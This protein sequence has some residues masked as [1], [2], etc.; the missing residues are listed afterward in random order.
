MAYFSFNRL[1]KSWDS[2]FSK[3][4]FFKFILIFFVL[5]ESSGNLCAEE[6]TLQSPD[7]FLK[8]KISSKT[9]ID[10]SS[11]LFYSVSFNRKEAIQESSLGI[12]REDAA[13]I[14]D[15]K[16]V[17][18]SG[19]K[20]IDEK[21]ALKTGKR[22]EAH[23]YAKEQ[24]LTFK[25]QKGDL[26][27]LIV[28]AYNEGVAFRY[29]FPEKDPKVYKVMGEMTEFSIPKNGKAWIHQYDWNSRLKPSY[30]QY[31]EKEIPIGSASP[32]E[33]GWAYPMLFNTNGLWMM[34]TEAV[35]DGS[36]CG[37]HIRVTPKGTYQVHLAEP[38][39]AAIP[40]APEPVHSLPWAS[41]WR[42]I[43]VGSEL[44][45]IVESNMVQNLNEACRIKNT[46]WIQPG[47]ASWSWWS[48]GG[49]PR[50]FK[51][52]IEYVDF[53]A[54]MG[55]EYMLIDAGWPEMKGGTVEDVIKYANRKKVGIW[56]WYHSGSG[57]KKDTVTV[58]N[59]MSIPVARRAE[60]ARLHTLGVKGV[61][62]DF[63]DTDKQQI[64]KL[65]E[66]IL[67]DAADNQIM[68]NF[69]G[70]SLPR[71]LERTYPNLMTTEA[72]RGAEGFGRQERCD[73]APNFHTILPFTRNVVGSMDYTPVTFSNKI[74]QGVEAFQK[75]SYAHQLALSVIFES[76][77]QDF[78][79]RYTSYQALPDAPK[80]FLKKVPA[81]WD[82]TRLV[83]G[84]P[85][86]FVVMARRK[87]NIWYVAG[88][89]GK[90]EKR[91][92]TFEL[93]FISGEKKISLIIDGADRT[94]FS[95]KVAKTG[96]KV[97]VSLLP[98]GGFAGT[99]EL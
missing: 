50:D 96:H 81:A 63:F 83:A 54:E 89:S 35:L 36:W 80:N 39:E 65:Y 4:T 12:E 10:K 55:W 85:G 66:E 68:V 51:K 91:E 26:L 18:Q 53:T 57:I 20:V 11:R 94:K 69:H 58:R 42:V 1:K 43:M 71:G 72:V 84:Y 8:I 14:N 46:E 32:N 5:A 21:Y 23:N 47:R 3:H 15:L 19:V 90:D 88:I 31:C 56:L 62:I 45:S 59:M 74:R 13:F 33:K 87:G 9:G 27:E 77:V 64:V 22:S 7:K 2:G 52:Q 98:N 99:V 49:S 34:V 93:P 40:D 67:R 24:I 25:N 48:E 79:D 61:K 16:L 70:A 95:E 28:R 92:L 86:D 97:T 76:G 82:E 6:W 44:A 29:R 75:T 78:A 30:E 17:S 37:T 41:P 73:N 38:D 60:F